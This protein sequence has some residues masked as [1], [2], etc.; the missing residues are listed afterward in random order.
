MSTQITWLPWG[1]RGAG[2]WVFCSSARRACQTMHLILRN[3]ID[4]NNEKQTDCQNNNTF[5]VTD[6]YFGTQTVRGWHALDF[7]VSWVFNRIEVDPPTLEVMWFELTYIYLSILN[8]SCTN[9]T[10]AYLTLCATL[11][12]S[13]FETHRPLDCSEPSTVI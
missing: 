9:S 2:S 12:P 10:L 5:I 1:P 6:Y 4:K 11:R 8:K 13:L 3:T 7:S